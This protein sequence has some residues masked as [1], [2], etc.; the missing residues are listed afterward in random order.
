M[1]P[2]KSIYFAGELFDHKHL[3][4]N[5]LL[6]SHLEKVCDGEYKCLLP[7]E[8]E[9]CS[10][11]S[12]DIRDQD[13]YLLVTSDLALFNFDGQDL[14]SGTVVEFMLAKML[15]IPSVILRT[16]LRSGGDQES[17]PWN[18]MCSEYPRTKVI[19][20]NGIEWYQN[21]CKKF[22]NTDDMISAMYDE[23]SLDVISGLKSVQSLPSLLGPSLDN[24]EAIYRW[25]IKFPGESFVQK[26]KDL[27]LQQ[28]LQSKKDKGLYNP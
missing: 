2:I 11:R 14:D 24:I 27:N 19:I 12:I 28:L 7:Q 9:Q 8:Y 4:G 3:I 5:K 15:D 10:G 6:A 16:D 13:L 21:Y 23:L 25:A 20:K 17:E 18:L 22:D 1:Q 26:C